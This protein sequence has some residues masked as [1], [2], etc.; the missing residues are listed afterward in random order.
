[1]EEEERWFD[2]LCGR[3]LSIRLLVGEG[4]KEEEK[5]KEERKKDNERRENEDKKNARGCEE[6][7][8]RSMQWWMPAAT[9]LELQAHTKSAKKARE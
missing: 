6:A 2:V 4:R 7:V 3:S 5:R 8:K 9:L 1:M